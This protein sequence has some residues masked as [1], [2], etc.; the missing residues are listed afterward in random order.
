MYYRELKEYERKDNPK[1]THAFEIDLEFTTSEGECRFS[2]DPKN[3]I[4]GL[5]DENK[6]RFRENINNYIKWGYWEELPP[7][8]EPAVVCFPWLKG[9]SRLKFVQFL[10]VEDLS[11]ECQLQAW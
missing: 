7:T 6:E 9:R 8:I 10:I 11:L 4:N 2:W 3:M 5:S 1:E